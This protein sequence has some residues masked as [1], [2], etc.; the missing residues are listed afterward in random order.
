MRRATET[1][2]DAL[3]KEGI[4]IHA[5]REEGDGVTKEFEGEEPPISIHA[6]RE[7]GDTECLSV[8]KCRY[9]SIHVLREEGDD[10]IRGQNA[11]IDISIHAL[12]EEGDKPEVNHIDGN[13]I[14][15]STPSVR[16]ATPRDGKRL[17]KIGYFN[18]RPP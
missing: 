11:C 14:F 9:I 4:S 16:R 5:L 17:E 2:I 3:I 1:D 12:R 10:D 18:P 6:L 15:Q 13:K 7:E 8:N